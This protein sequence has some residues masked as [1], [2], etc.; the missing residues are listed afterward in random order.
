MK[1]N[2]VTKNKSAPDYIGFAPYAKIVINQSDLSF[3]VSG[4]VIDI[5]DE[6]HSKNKL[7]FVGDFISLYYER[8]FL[9]PEEAR[10]I[11]QK[12]LD[13]VEFLEELILNSVG[14]FWAVHC[15]SEK[16]NVLCSLR[17]PGLFVH[18]DKGGLINLY[19]SEREFYQ[20]HISEGLDEKQC[21]HYVTHRFSF[22]APFNGLVQNT[23]RMIGGQKISV[24][25]TDKDMS[26]YLPLEKMCSDK[27][28]DEDALEE[29]ALINEGVL[30]QQYEYYK[31]EEN[32]FEISGGV[33]SAMLF[34]AAS[35]MKLD[36][37][38][39]HDHKSGLLS[40]YVEI[41]CDWLGYEK[42]KYL[43]PPALH[44]NPE[45]F[46]ACCLQ[47]LEKLFS[48]GLGQ[49][50]LGNMYVNDD[51][52]KNKP[53]ALGGHAVG[54][55][56]QGH[57]FM[58]VAFALPSFL[59]KKRDRVKQALRYLYTEEFIGKLGAEAPSIVKPHDRELP[60]TGYEYLS[61]M[62]I[63]NKTPLRVE[64]MLPTELSAHEDSFRQSWIDDLLETILRG[65]YERLKRNELSLIEL[66]QAMRVL[67]FA[68]NVQSIALNT[69]NVNSAGLFNQQDPLMEGPMAYFLMKRDVTMN[70]V[71]NPKHLEFMYFKK[72]T[73]K[74]Y[75]KDYMPKKLLKNI[76]SRF[77]KEHYQNKKLLKDRREALLDAPQ[78]HELVLKTIDPDK[79]VF[80]KNIPDGDVKDYIRSLYI[81]TRKNPGWDFMTVNNLLNLE[82]F[83]N[84]L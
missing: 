29:Y 68:T 2:V 70:E 80:L 28:P 73:G 60:K 42:P 47:N 24:S 43:Y 76:L 10:P 17:G 52:S 50:G 62:A 79:S 59:R 64:A 83:F 72:I 8:K 20:S 7:L 33:D 3:D 46:L 34:C 67:R 41:L 4:R 14:S 69:H 32:L 66:S 38:P 48:E 26:F 18:E 82:L 23:K 51:F 15:E 25:K 11:F 49:L 6:G 22:R 56:Y 44:K 71:K 16:V 57:P 75:F 37:T 39:V 63:S 84:K 65:S 9:T 1:T 5:Y 19:S 78:Y 77:T 13:D 35:K 58:F 81:K 27:S 40:D 55:L 61:N 54:V 45:D 31:S 36:V 74:D 21:L 53:L 12:H 30:K